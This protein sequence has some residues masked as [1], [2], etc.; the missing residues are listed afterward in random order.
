[1]NTLDGLIAVPS[2]VLGR[3]TSFWQSVEALERPA[4]VEVKI[5]R[6]SS[7][8]ENRNGLIRIARERGAAWIW[9]LDD[10]LVFYPDTLTR[11][12]RRFDNPAVE[13]V[14]PLSF[15]RR[16]PFKAIWF[17][18]DEPNVHLL[19]T[20]PL[21]GPLKAI[22]AGTFGGLLVRTAVFDRLTPPYVTMGQID[23]EHWHDDRDFCRKLIASGTQIWGD[24]TVV[25][26]H[27]TDMEIW[28]VYDPAMGW[29]MA[30][31][32]N[33]EPF[34]MAPWGSDAR[35]EQEPACLSK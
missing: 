19:E 2:P 29:V 15:M 16:P 17:E 33:A 25:L 27:T 8:A 23:P 9:F 24:S 12:L 35:E 18:G 20:L 22:S 6:G 7:P 14:I 11:L 32:R 13:V 4:N 30:L 3:Y 31:A 1:M 21:P 26:G 28:P 5:G 34:L 10:D